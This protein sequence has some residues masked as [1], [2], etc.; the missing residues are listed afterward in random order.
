MEDDSIK[1]FNPVNAG[2]WVHT[3]SACTKSAKQ[4]AQEAPAKMDKTNH[5]EDILFKINPKWWIVGTMQ[6]I[7]G[8]VRILR[9][10]R[11]YKVKPAAWTERMD[12]AGV[13][14]NVLHTDFSEFIKDNVYE[15]TGVQS[16]HYILENARQ[17]VIVND[18]GNFQILDKPCGEEK[19]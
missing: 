3:A 11:Y 7:I 8:F 16:A 15:L 12:A 14:N 17:Y 1:R 5:T 6:S 10:L 19:L 2:I 4:L 18:E 9:N 13:R